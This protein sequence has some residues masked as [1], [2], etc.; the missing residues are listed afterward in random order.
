MARGGIRGGDGWRS[1]HC[2]RPVRTSFEEGKETLMD[3]V[4]SIDD[5]FDT[6]R[7]WDGI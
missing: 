7:S 3:G 5:A 2:V 1:E 4:A 6:H